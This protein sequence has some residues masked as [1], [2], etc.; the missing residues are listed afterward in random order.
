VE[1]REAILPAGTLARMPPMVVHGFRNGS[2]DAEVRYLNLHAPGRGFA[3]YL[4][5]LRDW[6]PA[7]YDQEPPPAEGI[8]PAGDAVIGGAALPADV[9]EIGVAEMRCE[10]GD[11]PAPPHV[12]ERHLESL[13]VLEGELAVS[14]GAHELRA[15]AG[16]WVRLPAGVPHVVAAG[17]S[18]AARFLDV[19]TP[20]C[21]LG[22]LDQRP[23][24]G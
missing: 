23:A 8:R 20:S 19:H 14:A 17:G 24:A 7:A 1:G 9:E 11:P 18:R 21:G 22:R 6:L 16:S 12:H 5:A 4:R 13:Y 10:P 3:G 15:P 2:P